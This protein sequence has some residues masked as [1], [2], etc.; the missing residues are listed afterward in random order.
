ML[1]EFS[2]EGSHGRFTV[3]DDLTCDLKPLCVLHYSDTGSDFV[4]L[5]WFLC[6]KSMKS[7]VVLCM[8][9]IRKSVITVSSYEL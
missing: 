3:E 2:V 8:V 4:R 5:V 9:Q 6:D 1:R 7:R